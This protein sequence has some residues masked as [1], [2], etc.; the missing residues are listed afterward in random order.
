[1]S[2]SSSCSSESS[3]SSGVIQSPF[4]LLEAVEAAILA[5]C[6]MQEYWLMDRKVR[7]A[8]LKELREMRRELK[9]EIAQIQGTKPLGSSIN[10]QTLFN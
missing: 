10:V 5:V 4:A 7:Y 2:T 1:M 9:A 6:S 8:D 3:S